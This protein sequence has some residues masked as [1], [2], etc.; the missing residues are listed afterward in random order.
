MARLRF[1]RSKRKALGD[2]NLI[3]AGYCLWEN[4]KYSCKVGI[5]ADFQ[6]CYVLEIDNVSYG[7]KMM[8]TFPSCQKRWPFIIIE[9]DSVSDT[10]S[11]PLHSQNEISQLYLLAIDLQPERSG[12]C[13]VTCGIF[14][15]GILIFFK[16]RLLKLI[17]HQIK[18]QKLCFSK[19][20][21]IQSLKF[22][23]FFLFPNSTL[24]RCF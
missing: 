15:Y 8:S 5:L 6:I 3:Y 24:F 10:L 12:K 2:R 9:K 21:I 4:L 1:V 13:V 20:H 16:F 17:K 7:S 18:F 19:K 23:N 14:F 11:S 22:S